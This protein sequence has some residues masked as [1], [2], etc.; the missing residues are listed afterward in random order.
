MARVVIEVP[1]EVAVLMEK[2]PLLKLAIA[3]AVIRE[4]TEYLLAVMT[5]DKLAEDSK[6]GEEDVMRISGLVKR[7]VR[8]RWDAESSGR[9]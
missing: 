5:L 2:E 9:Y 3:E 6:L 7:A 4:V 8:E 1:E